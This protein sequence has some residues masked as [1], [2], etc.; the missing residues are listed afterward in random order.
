MTF[1]YVLLEART[2]QGMLL[3]DKPS[4]WTSFDVVNYVR[5]QARQ[6]AL[7]ES[8]QVAS[9]KSTTPLNFKNFQLSTPLPKVKVGHTGTLDPL[10]TGL[11]VL[12]VG[13][14]YTRRANE[15]SKLDK[16]YEVTM[17]LGQTSTTGDAEGQLTSYATGSYPI[18]K[19]TREQVL[20][21]LEG[22]TGQIMQTPPAYSAMKVNGK[23]AYQL[24]REGKPVELE[25]RPVIIHGIQLVS[26]NY[27]LVIFTASVSSG[28]YIRSLVAD[29]GQHLGAGAYTASL[30]RTRIGC[31]SLANAAPP[32]EV[33]VNEADLLE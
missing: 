13:K 5:K 7:V 23:R 32:S 27:P 4:G 25:P 21:A 15:F 18:A 3:I 28:T 16:T 11:L 17:K 20:S 12:L 19:P 10:A 14:D 1:R 33:C 9:K 8:Y 30:R 31:F 29:L 22:F 24:A 26:Y 2:M 6:A